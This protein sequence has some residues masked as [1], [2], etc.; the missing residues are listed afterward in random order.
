[1]NNTTEHVDANID[2]DRLAGIRA[3]LS[4]SYPEIAAKKSAVSTLL[5][6]GRELLAMLDGKPVS[7]F[8]GTPGSRWRDMQGDEWVLEDDGRMCLG[9]TVLD[10]NSVAEIYGPMTRAGGE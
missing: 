3:L 4:L 1:M 7:A 8:P 9:G 2:E 10:A 5:A 6:A